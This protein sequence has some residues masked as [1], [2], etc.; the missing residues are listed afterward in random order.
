MCGTHPSQAGAGLRD[1]CSTPAFR[2]PVPTQVRRV[3]DT[4]RGCS[5]EDALVLME[6]M[7][8]RAC[9][10]I[11]KALISVSTASSS[12]VADPAAVQDNYR[13]AGKGAAT[14]MAARADKM[15]LFGLCAH[16]PLLTRSTTRVP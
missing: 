10:R 3:L 6:Y 8:Y 13:T 1:P 9:E 14:V 5:Y 16:R 7:P 4:I 11:V 2:I 15:L 12:P